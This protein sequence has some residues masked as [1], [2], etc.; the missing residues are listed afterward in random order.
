MRHEL[1]Y[2]LRRLARKGAWERIEVERLAA[3]FGLMP[4]GALEVINEAAFERCGAPLLEGDETIEV[5]G[6]I[7]EEMSA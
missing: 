3:E 6:Q 2:G 5:D 1:R 4:D 7:L